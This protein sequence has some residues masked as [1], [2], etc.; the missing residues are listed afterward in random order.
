MAD[1]VT[2]Q[3]ALERA[4]AS[5]KVRRQELARLPYEQKIA[6]ALDLR[7]M[8]LSMKKAVVVPAQR[9]PSKR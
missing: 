7:A 1:R 9:Q 5:K 3:R 2:H 6:L 8:A 4:L